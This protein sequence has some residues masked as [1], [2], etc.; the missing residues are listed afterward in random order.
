MKESEQIQ[1]EIDE[2]NENDN[3]FK[4]LNLEKKKT[5]AKRAE[6]FDKLKKQLTDAGYEITEHPSQGKYT[7][8]P[9]DYGIIDFYPKANK[10]LIRKINQW[11][12]DGYHWLIH[13]LIRK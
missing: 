9:T 6:R 1:K 4:Y 13:K 12:P 7:I 5:R 10:V 8:T 11:K 2:L 3:D